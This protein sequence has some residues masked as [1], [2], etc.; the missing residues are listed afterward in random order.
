MGDPAV[1]TLP[2]AEKKFK[3]ELTDYSVRRD[4]SKWPYGDIDVDA[5][6]VGAGFSESRDPHIQVDIN[7]PNRC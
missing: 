6:I 2:Q 1:I 5:I 7:R 4:G 3:T